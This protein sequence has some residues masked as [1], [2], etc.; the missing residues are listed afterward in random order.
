MV[1]ILNIPRAEFPLRTDSTFLLKETGLAQD[2]LV[3][4]DEI[5]LQALHQAKQL[6]LT[7]VDHNVLPR[8]VAKV[9]LCTVDE[10]AHTGWLSLLMNL[11][12]LSV[13]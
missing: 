6:T 13:C 5:D 7:L 11:S 1:P 4:R 10:F 3:F 12:T 8:S 9:A 2:L